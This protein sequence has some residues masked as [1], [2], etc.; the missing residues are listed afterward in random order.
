MGR[1]KFKSKVRGPVGPFL[2]NHRSV[3]AS[4]RT[5]NGSVADQN[6]ASHWIPDGRGNDGEGTRGTDR[7]NIVSTNAINWNIP[8]GVLPAA[9]DLKQVILIDGKP[10]LVH[11]A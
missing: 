1:F 11:K 4:K 8:Q 7:N 9:A 10:W 5:G 2:T 3:T 6:V